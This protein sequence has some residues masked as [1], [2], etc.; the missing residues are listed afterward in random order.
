MEKKKVVKIKKSEKFWNNTRKKIPDKTPKTRMDLVKKKPQFFPR[1]CL[2][3]TWRFSREWFQSWIGYPEICWGYR[4]SF[5]VIL[6]NRIDMDIVYH[7]KFLL[8]FSSSYPSFDAIFLPIF[9]S[10]FLQQFP[11]NHFLSR[12]S[13]NILTIVKKCF[14]IKSDWKCDGRGGWKDPPRFF[15][16]IIAQKDTFLR[17]FLPFLM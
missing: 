6:L 14:W 11:P 9:K 1:P 2:K 15:F 8:Y 5:P 3:L 10:Y 12:P 16:E 17:P 7:L 4:S 13:R